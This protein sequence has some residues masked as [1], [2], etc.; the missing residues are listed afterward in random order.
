MTRGPKIPLSDLEKSI[1]A[2]LATATYPPGT[3]SKRFV[4]DLH[5]GHI[6]RLSA[7]GRAFLA[8]VAHRFR[9]Q[10]CLNEE[11]WAWINSHIEN[12]EIPRG[13]EV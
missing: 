9:K 11:E 6:S 5:G 3:A 10:Y 7:K 12:L 13:A 4:R 8:F 1:I 2:K